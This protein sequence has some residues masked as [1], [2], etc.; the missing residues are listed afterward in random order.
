M[1][2]TQ[3]AALAALALVVHLTLALTA[4]RTHAPT[5]DETA[6]LPAGFAAVAVGDFRINTQHPPLAKMVAGLPLLAMNVRLDR[7][8]PAWVDGH[9]WKF[10][11]RFLY[12]WNDADRLLFAGRAAMTSLS[13]LLGAAVYLW[14]R[15]HWGRGAAL[16]ALAFWATSPDVLAHGALVTNDLA[17]ACF[18][19]VAVAAFEWA[20]ERT[21]P[22]RLTLAGLA[23]GA[24]LL[25]KHSALLL[26]IVLPAL[27]FG[28]VWAHPRDALERPRYARVAGVL[29]IVAAVAWITVWAG[30]RFRFQPSADPA[31]TGTL[32]WRT[33]TDGIIDTAARFAAAHRLVPEAYAHGLADLAARAQSRRAFLLGRYSSD[34]WWYYFPIAFALKT[35]LPLLALLAL[36][37]AAMPRG[38][39]RP[40]L[41]L[42]LPALAFALFALTTRVNIGHRYVLPLVPFVLIAA[43]RAAAWIGSRGRTGAWLA[44]LLVVWHGVGTLR[45]HPHYLAYFNEIAG[46]PYGGYRYLADSNVDWGQDLK[47]LAAYLD[48]QK[49]ERVRLSYFGTAPPSLYHIPH[50]L[51]PSVMRPFPERFLVHVRP[52]DVVVVSATN[53]QGVYLP[54]AVRHL[55]ER[56]RAQ[57]PMARVGPSLFVYR[58]DFHWLLRPELAEEAGWLPQAIESYRECARDDPDQ[59][60]QAQEF[61]AAAQDRLVRPAGGEDEAPSEPE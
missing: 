38:A 21:T 29:A 4:A 47:R 45:T 51:L 1:S 33:P 12:E 15:R 37:M 43:G 59:R 36:A 23:L 53:L 56:L 57:T 58:A 26:A 34:G 11:H 13:V 9:A 50:D 32:N 27:A 7:T 44:G 3:E 28:H 24:A 61:L 39:P 8:D 25:S 16:F 19:F 55:M 54:R 42:W 6:Y 48:E 10:G 60:A 22:A 18:F 46:G 31:S 35:P 40:A 30:Y 17:V 52:G 41:F 14:T 2:R 49:I 20:L 5:F